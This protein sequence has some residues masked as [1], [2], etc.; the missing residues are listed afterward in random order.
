M[1][2][3]T[4][5]ITNALT[6]VKNIPQTGGAALSLTYTSPINGAT[7]SVA[8]TFPAIL[9]TYNTAN[10]LVYAMYQAVLGISTFVTGIQTSAA[11]FTSQMSSISSSVSSIQSTLNSLVS[12]IDS[13]DSS[14]STFLNYTTYPSQY[15]NLAL[16]LLFGCM[17]GFSSLALFGAMFTVCCRRYS[18]RHLMYFSCLFLFFLALVGFMISTLFSVLVP[19]FTWTCTYLSTTISS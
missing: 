15:G 2:N 1:L 6:A 8:S 13:M 7:G 11:S 10:T 14:L 12:S 17:I 18:C 3:S 5:A 9:G 16:T 19:V 4:T